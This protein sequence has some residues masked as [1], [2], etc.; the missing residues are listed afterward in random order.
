MTGLSREARWARR[1]D[2][3]PHEVLDAAIRIF[4]EKGYH[5]ATMEE[6][7]AAAGVGKGTVYHYFPNKE[8]LLGALVDRAV[9]T[10]IV[11]VEELIQD[12]WSASAAVKLRLI[13][14]RGRAN[15]L[16]P[17]ASTLTRIVICDVSQ[18]APA[19]FHKWVELVLLRGARVAEE[20]IREG[21][22]NGEF[23]RDVDPAA[24][25]RF[26][27]TAVQMQAMLYVGMGV[28]ALD[29]INVVTMLD[30][31][32]DIFLRG[33]EPTSPSMFGGVRV[34]TEQTEP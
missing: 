8:A 18:A 22:W 34:V 27:A 30:T 6:I 33:L 23:R 12:G 32:L 21:Q 16:S 19:L 7:A 3:R 10:R 24:A 31:S 28:M 20:L 13:L 15:L 17:E 5:N 9:E 14:A 1:P 11:P 2:D 4:G 25:A 26:L 29:P